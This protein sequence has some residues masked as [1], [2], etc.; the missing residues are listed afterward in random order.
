MRGDGETPGRPR[1]GGGGVEQDNEE[2]ISHPALRLESTRV[3]WHVARTVRAW[4]SAR[5]SVRR[6]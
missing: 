6:S 5:R 1:G 2:S 3:V 4:V